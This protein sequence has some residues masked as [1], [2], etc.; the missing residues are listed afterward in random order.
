MGGLG[1][2][3]LGDALLK[4]YASTETVAAF[5]VIVDA[6]DDGARTFYERN[7]FQRMA[8]DEYRLFISMKDIGAS[9]L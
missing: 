2:I 1:R 7:G 5:A 3:L 6:K 9:L 8:D 4:A